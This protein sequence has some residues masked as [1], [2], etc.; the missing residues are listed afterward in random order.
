[1]VRSLE[2]GFLEKIDNTRLNGHPQLRLPNNI[3]VSIDYIEGE[4][5]MLN[6]DHEGICVSTGSACSSS[7]HGPSHVLLAMGMPPQQAYGSLRITLGRWTTEPHI[8]YLLDSL[9][10]IITKLRAMSPLAVKVKN[11][12]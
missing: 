3:N 6:L 7:E 5:V 8:E 11:I 10:K 2:K 4:S 9:I 12:D 1:M